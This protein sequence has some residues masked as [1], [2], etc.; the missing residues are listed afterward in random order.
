M[1]LFRRAAKLRL[2]QQKIGL[3][4][5]TLDHRPSTDLAGNALNVFAS[6]PQPTGW[7]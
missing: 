6:F 7:Y 2:D 3:D 5:R 1:G 4:A